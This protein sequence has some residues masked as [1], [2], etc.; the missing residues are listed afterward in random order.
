MTYNVFSGTLNPTHVLLCVFVVVEPALVRVPENAAVAQGSEVTL[1]CSSDIGTSFLTWFNR[2]CPRYD[3]L[4]D[5]V[6]SSVIYNG[7]NDHD[8]PPRFTIASILSTKNA[9]DDARTVIRNVNIRQTQP[10]DAGDYVC[11]ENIRGQG[12]QQTSSA[13]LVILG[14]MNCYCCFR[15]NFMPYQEHT[16]LLYRKYM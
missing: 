13:Q 9:T 7:F 11:V 15:Q 3:D 8:N 5:C 12:V 4:N 14:K 16:N 1:D 2:S 6:R 10:T